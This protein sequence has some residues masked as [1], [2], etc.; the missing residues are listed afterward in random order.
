MAVARKT[1]ALQ[2]KT[3]YNTVAGKAY[4]RFHVPIIIDFFRVLE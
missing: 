3:G 2:R 1:A 4:D